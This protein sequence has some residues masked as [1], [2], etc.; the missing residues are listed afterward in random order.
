MQRKREEKRVKCVAFYSFVGLSLIFCLQ[1]TKKFSELNLTL[2]LACVRVSEH[3]AESLVHVHPCPR[4]STPA[5]QENKNERK[6]WNETNS[7][8]QTASGQTF[9]F[10]WKD[11]CFSVRRLFFC[12]FRFHFRWSS[13]RF[14]FID[15]QMIFNSC[16]CNSVTRTSGVFKSHLLSLRSIQL[17]QIDRN[18]HMQKSIER[19]IKN[20]LCKRPK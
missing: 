14:V 6:K 11:L 1:F 20:A 5:E 12:A 16:I 15:K 4:S 13:V 9:L 10:R 19:P 18:R 17:K 3:R 7:L 2:A 8:E